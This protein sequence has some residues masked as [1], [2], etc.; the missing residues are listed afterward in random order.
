M[1]PPSTPP[2]RM[3]PSP[4]PSF[5]SSPSSRAPSMIDDP[6]LSDVSSLDDEDYE[7]IEGRTPSAN[8][9]S[10]NLSASRSWM[11]DSVP[12]G[13]PRSNNASVT[14]SSTQMGRSTE[15]SRDR[16]ESG[17]T[18]L[19]QSWAASD[20][21]GAVAL[22]QT[23]ADHDVDTPISSTHHL[24][25]PGRAA[26]PST[27]TMAS[28]AGGSGGSTVSTWILPD[29]TSPEN[30]INLGH[31]QQCSTPSVVPASKRYVSHTG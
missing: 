12:P 25:Q 18:A 6:T 21:Q 19:D 4:S 17:E 1:A 20:D 13:S 23:S 3:T 8:Y 26:V 30:S 9:A 2:P 15:P 29:P 11:S 28:N 27:S 31:A 16:R 22:G 24:I 7:L 14:A 5:P 10:A